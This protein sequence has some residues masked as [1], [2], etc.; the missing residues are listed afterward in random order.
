MIKFLIYFLL[1]V[2]V[3]AD[4]KVW[5]EWKKKYNKISSLNSDS[6][7]K[8]YEAFKANLKLIK[9]HNRLNQTSYKLGL[10]EYSDRTESE[11]FE[12]F[13]TKIKASTKRYPSKNSSKLTPK[14]GTKLDSINWAAEGYL[15]PI[16]SQG[17]KCGSC[18]AF[19]TVAFYF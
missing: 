17:P 6:E 5:Q 9:E 7:R 19:A 4:L 12:I 1:L 16:Q 14:F 11:L 15:P 2:V 13:D 10:N 8:R 18:Y 3:L